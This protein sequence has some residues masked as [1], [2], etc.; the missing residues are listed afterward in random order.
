LRATLARGP[1]GTP[2]ARPFDKQ[3]SA[4]MSLLARADCLVVR[5]PLASAAA[6]GD[7]VEIILLDT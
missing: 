6:P 5:Q 3:D 7:S 2:E 4:M 1:D